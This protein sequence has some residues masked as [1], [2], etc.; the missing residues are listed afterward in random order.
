MSWGSFLSSTQGF[1]GVFSSQHCFVFFMS[2]NKLSA[3][4]LSSC[5]SHSSN[6]RVCACACVCLFVCFP[7][8]TK[9]IEDRL[10]R[11]LEPVRAVPVSGDGGGGG[12]DILRFAGRVFSL[13]DVHMLL[14]F[15]L[16]K[17]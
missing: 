4:F 2:S 9:A 1:D 14:R 7:T 12:R 10:G 13:P 8:Q 11:T 5:S 3:F 6:L 15:Y 17:E 16:S